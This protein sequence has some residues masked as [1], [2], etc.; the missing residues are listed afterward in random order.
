MAIKHA[1][2]CSVFIADDKDLFFKFK[3]S[4]SVKVDSYDERNLLN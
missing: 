1:Q 3:T 4:S 2:A